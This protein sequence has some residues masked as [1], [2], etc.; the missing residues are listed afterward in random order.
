VF[1]QGGKME[2]LETRHF[3]RI[4]NRVINLDY[5]MEVDLNHAGTVVFIINARGRSRKEEPIVTECYEITFSGPEAK[6]IL[7][8]FSHGTSLTLDTLII[9]QS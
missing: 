6:A 4:G 3:L 7:D 8:Y 2:T 9:P 5:V 1:S